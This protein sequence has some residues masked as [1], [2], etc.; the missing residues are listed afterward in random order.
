MT[1]QHDIP[2]K[3]FHQLV[4]DAFNLR[5][6]A[7]LISTLSNM[8]AIEFTL[9]ENDSS[10]LSAET[11]AATCIKNIEI[12]LS[13]T[14]QQ[15]DDSFESATILFSVALSP[16]DNINNMDLLS[17]LQS[18]EEIVDSYISS[19][20]SGL[21]LEEEQSMRDALFVLLESDEVEAVLNF[22]SGDPKLLISINTKHT[23]QMRKVRAQLIANEVMDALATKRRTI[24]E[25]LSNTVTMQSLIQDLAKYASSEDYQKPRV[26]IAPKGIS[27]RKM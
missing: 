3:I 13:A 23:T 1:K 15:F 4:N 27:L 2:V 8:L 25:S 24:D 26:A 7:K 14:N 21:S 10:H 19:H 5:F 18:K 22:I 16:P 11:R 9:H 17:Q 6:P 12:Y 20:A